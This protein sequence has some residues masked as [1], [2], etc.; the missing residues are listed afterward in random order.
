MREKNEAETETERK[1][2]EDAFRKVMNKAQ[3][4]LKIIKTNVMKAEIIL[5]M[6]KE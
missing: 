6:L 4:R 2:E 5:I 1:A 3:N